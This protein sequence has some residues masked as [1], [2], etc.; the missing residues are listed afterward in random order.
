MSK[1]NTKQPVATPEFNDVGVAV[2]A[3]SPEAMLRRSVLSTM[4]WEDNAYGIDGETVAKRIQTLVTKCTPEYVSDLAKAARAE[5]NLRHVPLLL[6]RELARTCKLSAQTLAEIIQRPDEM[7]EFLSIYW[8][9]GKTA[10]SNQ[11][12]KGLAKCFSKFNEYQLAK[13]DS[14]GAAVALRDVMFLCHPKPTSVAQEEL[15]KRIANKGLQTPDT[16]EV[17]LSAGSDKKETFSRLMKENKLG[18]LAFIKNLRGMLAAGVPESEIRAYSKNIN[19]ERVLPFRYIAAVKYVPELTDMLEDMMFRT[20][21][22]MPKLKGRTILVVDTSGSM[23]SSI[24][25]KSE[26]NRMQAAAALAMMAREICEEVAIYATAGNDGRRT[27][28]TMRIPAHRGFALSK[29]ITGGEVRAKI[30]QGGIFMVQ[31]MDWIAE[32]E[33][34]NK[35]DRVLVFTD[36]NDCDYGRDPATAKVIAPGKSYVMNIAAHRNGI[37]SG[38]YEVIS[39]FSEAI[40]DYI[41][42]V[43]E[44]TPIYPSEAVWP[45]PSKN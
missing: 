25:A 32:Q 16:W 10:V 9:D 7:G 11:V 2:R 41:R 26:I 35:V 12:K 24:S 19:L 44:P 43:E 30:G 34:G 13:W 40:L 20:L 45:F 14:N 6:A 27:H 22:S 29:F 42:A 28:A 3:I 37:N 5:Y 8:K 31:V 17:A 38:R 18:A 15:F 33:K 39:G 4:L 36:E 23:G 1:L 21:A